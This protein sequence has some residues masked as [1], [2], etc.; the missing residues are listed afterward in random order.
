MAQEVSLEGSAVDTVLGVYSG[1]TL[2]T[3]QLLATNDD[4][5]AA[6]DL[7]SCLVFTA[8]VDQ[9]YRFDY[10]V[11]VWGSGWGVGHG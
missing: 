1:S 6:A 3:L 8:V 9:T 11:V 4:C 10:C 5:P 2:D 7:Y